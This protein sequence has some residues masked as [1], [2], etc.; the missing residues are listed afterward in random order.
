MKEK[1]K[2][3]L[4]ALLHAFSQNLGW[5]IF[6]LAAAILLWSYIVTSDPTITRDKTLSGV[7]ITTSGLTV[8]Q[9]RDLA[10]LTD[11]EAV[12]KDVRVRVEVPRANYA[13][14]TSDTV[15]VELDL[16]QIRQTG[17]QE[18]ELKG[19]SN[20]GEVVQISPARIEV[21]VETLD[22][23]EVPVNVELTGNKDDSAY[24]YNVSRTNPSTI[25]VSGPSSVVQS[26]SAAKATVDVTGTTHNYNWTVAPELLDQNGEVISTSL[27]KSSSS[28]SVG[29]SIYPVKLLAVDTAIE[30]T[31]TGQILD[32]YTIT[33]VEVQPERISVA[34]EQELLDQLETLT[35]PPVNITGRMQS[36]STTVS[37]TK[38]NRIQ[39]MSSEQVTVTVYVEEN[40]ESHTFKSVPL[41]VIGK[42]IDQTIKLSVDKLN[43]KVTGLHTIF[44]KLYRGD[45]IANVD[46]TGLEP[47]TYELPVSVSVAAYPDLIFELE[48][49][50]VT[51][52]ISE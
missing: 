40:I 7:D 9:S 3:V 41:G 6:S 26:I 28:V 35:F 15:R 39:H 52:T 42:G 32:G 14:V 27:S 49:P 12:L 19:V 24:W 38:L 34:A 23:R 31:T 33:R 25:T 48:S 8:L 30:T 2:A 29:V 45:I 44:D 37:L 43:V 47:G 36:F 50:T 22:Q 20:Y 4:R 17:K 1:I 21:E 13:R 10:L 18:I 16:S 11:P 51:V 46:I 5:K